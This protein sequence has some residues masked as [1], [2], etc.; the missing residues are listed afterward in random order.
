MRS[1]LF[2]L[3]LLPTALPALGQNVHTHP[4][5]PPE[6]PVVLV[7]ARIHPVSRGVIEDG[8]LRMEDGRIVAVGGEEVSLAGAKVIDLGGLSVYPGLIAANSVLGLVEIEAVRAT[9]DQTEVA[10]VAPEVR[11]EIAFNPDSELIPV[12]RANGVLSV[13]VRPQPGEGSLITGRSALMALDG[14]T[15]EDMRIAGPVALHLAWPSEFVPEGL[16]D[17]MREEWLKAV[18]ERRRRLDLSFAEARAYAKAPPPALPDLRWEAMRGLFDGSLPL[19]IHADDASAIEQALA[20]ARE[21]QVRAV[22]VGG[23]EAWKVAATLRQDG[24]PVILGGTHVL[25]LRRH[26]PVDAVFA[27]AL[28]LHEAGV[29]FAIASPGDAFSSSNERNL[30]Y[31]AASA[32]AHGLPHEEGLRAITLYP[33]QILGVD[34][35]LGSLDPGK[36]ATLFVADG[37]PLEVSTRVLR[38]FVRGRE[39]DLDNRHLRLYEKYRAKY[40]QAGGGPGQP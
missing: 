25:P 8:R 16:P 39:V 34:D 13:L 6:G 14:W 11:A 29:R 4:L 17:T 9:V 23:A 18:R 12:T 28:R 2:L 26:D 5:P 40:R 7:N 1:F 30:P 36:D 37:D 21:Q 10:A 19:F 27:N 20:F 35:R 22:L 32:V 15:W 31:Q 24:V 33:A 38:A 3:A